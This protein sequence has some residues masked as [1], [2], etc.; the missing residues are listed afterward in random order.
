MRKKYEKIYDFFS[1]FYILNWG[2]DPTSQ[3]IFATL[4]SRMGPS[5]LTKASYTS[6]IEPEKL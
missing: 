1:Y 2:K 6:K 5:K 3:S 4:P